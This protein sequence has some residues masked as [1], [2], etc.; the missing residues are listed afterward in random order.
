MTPVY[1]VQGN[2]GSMGKIIVAMIVIAIVSVGAYFV[3][4]RDSPSPSPS[5]SPT[6]SPIPSNTPSLPQPSATPPP[7][8]TRDPPRGNGESC[9]LNP[10]CESRLCLGGVCCRF[11][12]PNGCGACRSI[13]EEAGARDDHIAGRGSCKNC[14]GRSGALGPPP[15]FSSNQFQ[16]GDQ[17]DPATG[18]VVILP[19]PSAPPS[20][21]QPSQPPQ[22][23]LDDFFISQ[24]FISLDTSNTCNP[25][26]FDQ[27]WCSN[28]MSGNERLYAWCASA[29]NGEL[30]DGTQHVRQEDGKQCGPMGTPIQMSGLPSRNTTS[31]STHTTTLGCKCHP[32]TAFTAGW[33]SFAGNDSGS[34]DNWLFPQKRGSTNSGDS[35][36][37]MYP[38]PESDIIP[39]DAISTKFGAGRSDVITPMSNNR[40]G[41]TITNLS[42]SELNGD[43]RDMQLNAYR[44]VWT[45]KYDTPMSIAINRWRHKIPANKED[46]PC[47][48]VCLGK[49]GLPSKHC[50]MPKDS[51]GRAAGEIYRSNR[52]TGDPGDTTSRPTKYGTGRPSDQRSC[53][54]SADCH[55]FPIREYI[56][57]FCAKPNE[58]NYKSYWQTLKIHNLE[59]A[60][61]RQD[62][63]AIG[64]NSRAPRLKVNRSPIQ[65][66]Y[67]SDSNRYA[68]RGTG[69]SGPTPADLFSGA[70]WL[71]DPNDHNVDLTR[72]TNKDCFS[73]IG[74]SFSN[75]SGCAVY[76][77]V[78]A[79]LPPGTTDGWEIGGG[80]SEQAFYGVTSAERLPQYSEHY[81]TLATGNG[82]K[83]QLCN[84]DSDCEGDELKCVENT[85]MRVG[86][87]VHT[88]HKQMR[89]DVN[90]P[91]IPP[92]Y[93]WANPPPSNVPSH[94]P[95]TDSNEMVKYTSG[96]LD[97]N[98]SVLRN[99]QNT[100]AFGTSKMNATGNMGSPLRPATFPVTG[101]Y[102][103]RYMAP[104]PEHNTRRNRWVGDNYDL[105][106]INKTERCNQVAVP[107][108]DAPSPGIDGTVR[109]GGQPI[110][111]AHMGASL[112]DV[113][114]AGSYPSGPDNNRKS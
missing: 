12:S 87:G 27:K 48:M 35:G 29:P 70:E 1:P 53:N 97:T 42:A 60:A 71:P 84:N 105:S 112:A 2:G 79:T 56:P 13:S 102:E 16:C 33:Q 106:R 54:A 67:N 18:G 98:Y 23:Y 58:T 55:S 86:D 111:G 62:T 74:H 4:F 94:T 110:T 96:T 15:T 76:F 101:E 5:P 45:D 68:I 28:N 17:S 36:F 91:K 89:G 85:F 32:Y 19:L 69:N 9:S 59:E 113:N 93:N 20:Q 57:R 107:P 43:S 50:S 34:N 44:G 103:I 51:H 21:P 78:G 25:V 72:E 11:S 40:D 24:E 88:Y 95:P 64:F 37:N 100:D 80:P 61:D 52:S 41:Q 77:D 46:P 38:Y 7:I 92:N 47:S 83:G 90:A 104:S 109:A 10:Q 66:G 63:D 26:S 81:N 82:R 65:F 39:G 114:G 14:S 22:D 49:D 75:A 6:P 31:D 108:P 73:N 8:V 99:Y 3:F 30:R